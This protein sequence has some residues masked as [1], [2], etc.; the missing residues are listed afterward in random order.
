M[1]IDV[2]TR[3]GLERRETIAF[4][5]QV[6]VGNENIAIRVFKVSDRAW[7]QE[8]AQLDLEELRFLL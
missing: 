1:S 5:L 4:D 8:I 2:V 7:D 3:D 6:G